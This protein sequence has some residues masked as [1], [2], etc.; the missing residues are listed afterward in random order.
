[1][2]VCVGGGEGSGR[3]GMFSVS[4]EG[5]ERLEGVEMGGFSVE[6][7]GEGADREI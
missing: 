1:M 3:R 4:I 5:V 2:Y 6:D 7:E